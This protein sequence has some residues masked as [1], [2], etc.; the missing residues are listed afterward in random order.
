MEGIKSQGCCGQTAEIIKENMPIT[1]KY[2]LPLFEQHTVQFVLDMLP[3]WDRPFSRLHLYID[4]KNVQ[5]ASRAV[6]EFTDPT[7]TSNKRCVFYSFHIFMALVITF[8]YLLIVALFIGGYTWYLLEAYVIFGPY[9]W[10]AIWSAYSKALC[11]CCEDPGPSE[12]TVSFDPNTAICA[13]ST[14]ATAQPQQVV[15]LYA[16]QTSSDQLPPGW[17]K[18]MTEDGREYYVHDATKTTQWEKPVIMDESVVQVVQVQTNENDGSLPAGWR[19]MQTSDGRVYFQ[20]DISKATQ[21][22]RPR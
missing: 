10:M 12:V 1:I 17:R 5:D 22:E 8:A 4:G 6:T 2:Q 15:T 7:Y 13:S 14:T 3:L 19:Q 18:A 21:W 20:N 11:D 16:G 9:T